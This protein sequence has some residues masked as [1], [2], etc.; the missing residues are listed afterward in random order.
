MPRLSNQVCFH[1]PRVGAQIHA[2]LERFSVLLVLA[3]L[4]AICPLAQADLGDDQYLQIYTLIQQAD[5]LNSNGEAGLAKAKY[6]EAQTALKSFKTD[7]PNWNVKLVASRLNYLAQKLGDPLEKSRPAAGVSAGSNAPE[8]QAGAKAPASTSTTQVKLLDAGAE[9]RKVLRLHPTPGDKQVLLLNLK[10]TLDT[11]MENAQP[12]PVKRPPMSGTLDIPVEVTVKGVTDK[13]DITYEVVFRDSIVI[14]ESE[15][16]APLD[17]KTKKIAS[18]AVKEM[19]A[20]GIVSSHGFSKGFQFKRTP[21]TGSQTAL[22]ATFRLLMD[23]M[24]D[25]FV[26][27]TPPLPEEAVGAGAKWEVKAPAQLQGIK[28]DQTPSYELVSVQGEH[29]KIKG[30]SALRAANQDIDN[31][32]MRGMKMDLAGAT[33]KIASEL[34]LD[35][36]KL[37]PS[38]G[39]MDIHSELKQR[40]K[41]GAQTQAITMKRDVNLRIEAK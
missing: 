26:Q 9:P 19:S 23:L 6:R 27:L 13:G 28:V 39:T 33:G 14:E 15:G 21:S 4:L 16:A 31:P 17:A 10:A 32:I 36:D 38:S 41:A 20:T 7:Y 2:N 30:I 22:P 11:K 34:S 5:E 1:E 25:A 8:A 18:D 3:L 29:L 24:W 35:A 40:V 12:P 37:M